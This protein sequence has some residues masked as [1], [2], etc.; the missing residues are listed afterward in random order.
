V[1]KR[2]SQPYPA[3]SRSV[4]IGASL[5][6]TVALVLGSLVVMN[7]AAS[8]EE[9]LTDVISGTVSI[10]L[11]GG[12]SEA[13]GADDV[14]VTAYRYD[15]QL[16]DLVVED[17]ALTQSDGSWSFSALAAGSYAFLYDYRG[18]DINIVDEFGDGSVS[19]EEVL[20]N[21]NLTEL[22]AGDAQSFS[23]T[24]SLGG[25]VTGTLTG[26]DSAPIQNQTVQLWR[27]APDRSGSWNW[28]KYG[29]SDVTDPAGTYAIDSIAPGNYTLQFGSGTANFAPEYWD[30]RYVATANDADNFYLY[31][32]GAVRT[33]DAELAIGGTVTGTVKSSSGTALGGIV[34]TA[35]R[36]NSNNASYD[37]L[38]TTTTASNGTYKLTA[39]AGGDYTVGFASSA[40]ATSQYVPQYWNLSSSIDSASTF[41]LESGSTRASVNA[42]LTK[43]GSI[44]GIISLAGGGHPAANDISI[45]ACNA[46]TDGGQWLEC[47]TDV[48]DSTY[49]ATTGAYRVLG[50]VPGKYSIYVE[51]N[52][53]DNF[54]SEYFDNKFTESTATVLAV[55]ATT[56][57]TGKNIQL[58]AG[59][60]V[61]GTVLADGLPVSNSW[62]YAT[63]VNT[64]AWRSAPT[65]ASGNFS[66]LGLGSGQ[67]TIQAQPGNAALASQYYDGTYSEGKAKKVSVATG[68]TLSGVNFALEEAISFDATVTRSLGGEPVEGA[69]VALYR[70][71]TPGGARWDRQATAYSDS[72]G[73][74]DFGT[75]I[76]P[77]EFVVCAGPDFFSSE[78]QDLLDGCVGATPGYSFEDATRFAV[79]AGGTQSVAV[80]LQKGGS[81]HGRVVD[82]SGDPVEGITVDDNISWGESTTT[83]E[84][85]EFTLQGFAEG[86]HQV[87][88][89]AW[90]DDNS[91]YDPAWVG[92]TVVDAPATTYDADAVE[93]GDLELK[94]GS[95]VTGTIIGTNG[96]AVGYT[97]VK[98]YVVRAGVLTLVNSANADSSG[99][100]SI[101]SLPAEPIYL[102]FTAIDSTKYSP[103]FLGGGTDWSLSEPVSFIDE[104][105]TAY[106]EVRLYNGATLTG[107]VTNKATGK[108][109]GGVG[110][111]VQKSDT[112]EPWHPDAYGF[113]NSK[114][115]YVIPGLAAGDYYLY[116]SLYDS[117]TH[118]ESQS[119]QAYLPDRTTTTVN[120]SLKPLY[121]VSGTATAS[122]G[123]PVAG[124]EVTPFQYVAG[125]GW[126][127]RGDLN[128]NVNGT[129][130][131]ETGAF[132]IYLP[133]GT[134]TLRF[135]D[136]DNE[137]APAF[138][139]GT[140]SADDPATST[141]VVTTKS[142]SGK[143]IVLDATT[144][145]IDAT[146]T[147]S[148]VPDIAGYLTLERMDGATVVTSDRYD[149]WVDDT[150]VDDLFPIRN[151]APGTYRLTISGGDSGGVYADT[152]IDDILVTDDTVQL[153]AIELTGYVASQYPQSVQGAGPTVTVLTDLTV[154]EMVEANPGSWTS[155]TGGFIYQWLRGGKVIAGADDATYVLAPGDAGK[156]ISFRVAA[157]DSAHPGDYDYA[158][159]WTVATPSEV[160]SDGEAPFPLD[161]PG[162]SGIA[163]NGQTVTALSGNW[164]LP[165]LTY[166]Y[167]WV[168]SGSLISDTV[169][170]RAASYKLTSADVWTADNNVQ[171]TL[172][173]TASRAGFVDGEYSVAV[174]NV[175]PA[176]ALKQT[177][178]SAV[179]GIIDG[180]KV[181]SG[182][183]SPTPS[184]ITYEWRVYDA[185]GE[186][187]TAVAEDQVGSSASITDLPGTGT[188]RV[189][190]AVTASRSGYTTTTV[191]VPV[192][193][194]AAVIVDTEPTITGTARVG[195]PLTVDA[196]GMSTTP[197]QS[198]LSYQWYRGASK[199]SG[200][201][202]AVYSLVSADAGAT[203]TVQVTASSS[204]Y[205]TSVPVVLSAGVV[206]AA[207]PFVADAP[208]IAGTPSLGRT[209]KVDI[210]TWTPTPTSVTYQWRRD[211]VAISKATKSSYVIG[212]KDVGTVISVTV[213]G[214][215][216]GF[217]S[218]TDT[219][220]GVGPID[221]LAPQSVVAPA[222]STTARVDLKLTANA[223]TWDVKPSTF[224]YQWYRNGD[225]I[226]GATASSFTPL[227][228]D[229]GE[230]LAVGVTPVKSGYSAGDEVLSNAVTVSLG[231]AVKASKVPALSVAGKAATSAKLGQSV[232]ATAGTWPVAALGLTYQWQVDRHDGNGWVDIEGQTTNSLFLEETDEDYAAVG[233]SIRVQVSAT[234]AGHAAA[235]DAVSAGLTIKP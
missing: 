181:T 75:G 133:A 88:V 154:G 62:V 194:G 119:S 116:Y 29:S 179:S 222:L 202:K 79:A 165:G 74:V 45:Q 168:R 218:V 11:D 157:I 107:K 129:I 143:N 138:L 184:A 103:Q 153:G 41:A 39:L 233:Y 137:V 47:G 72:S 94:Q 158:G 56:A 42:K 111:S 113:T 28:E 12:G 128:A 226:P 15:T 81:Y 6:A 235:P 80:E 177:K 31:G 140:D 60:I 93:L 207:Q 22:S 188:E 35:Y 232:K 142:L 64:G 183:W 38:A 229:L 1:S 115:A 32:D 126:V 171:V 214:S 163:R 112:E 213:R 30:D 172:H 43:G 40:T 46:H 82:S 159:P 131:Q 175:V 84:N 106:R 36:W 201:T 216:S 227:V 211:G 44:A 83:D 234:Q 136:S 185:D 198:S 217:A 205:G 16:D 189:T 225:A 162:Y 193:L 122:G 151:L 95:S 14:L 55:T 124:L 178:K 123:Q 186:S 192:R 18:A 141:F 61:T 67:Y 152:V 89:L 212:T 20:Y 21:A 127:D 7:T 118:V 96:K 166:T 199:I 98:A 53:H 9:P 105:S 85:G 87:R 190:V 71:R 200:A 203:V 52:G 206:E 90:D 19:T 219:S 110:V 76:G 170:S 108:A 176:T 78:N 109:I 13:A 2:F 37:G 195:M 91:G 68:A 230:D 114:G 150:T 73:H 210:G 5:S 33:F 215:R 174:A 121:T 25:I 66:I 34:V 196:T 167:S 50:M 156:R 23:Y 99:R 26:P 97:D 104:G 144:G 134:W 161:T 220:V 160:V 223:G 125:S 77:G 173:V 197:T 145:S 17:S 54:V 48:A 130:D 208:S 169:V 182:T 69:F 58:N 155:T 63:P 228:S 3:L 135:T 49:D 51:Y 187:Y 92:E 120:A 164:N 24:M 231:L 221:T 57:V 147:G 27:Q 224:R 4:K 100:F 139:G 102:K 8:A 132:A 149:S 70:M 65:D 204:G 101:T 86:A 59:G 191:E 10:A 117:S 148:V 146:V 209:L 180:Y